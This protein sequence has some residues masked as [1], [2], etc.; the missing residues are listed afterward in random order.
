MNWR[1]EGAKEMYK[2]GFTPGRYNPCIYYNPNS[3]LMTLDHGDDFV[4][5][6]SREAAKKFQEQL[7]A[8]LSAKQAFQEK[9]QEKVAELLAISRSSNQDKPSE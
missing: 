9:L 7:Q 2:W 6:G 5:V 1:E 4:S 3:K 8:E